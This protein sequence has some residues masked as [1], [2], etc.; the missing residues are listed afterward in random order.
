MT[1]LALPLAVCMFCAALMLSCGGDNTAT[2]KINIGLPRGVSAAPTHVGFIDRVLGFFVTPAYAQTAPEDVTAI[3]IT[4]TGPNMVP[5][6]KTFPADTTVVTLAVN[7]GKKRRIAVRGIDNTGRPKYI[8]SRVVNLEAGSMRTVRIDMGE[9]LHFVDINPDSAVGSDPSGMTLYK[10]KVYF[11]GYTEATGAELWAYD[12]DTDTASLKADIRNVEN[13][14]SSPTQLTVFNGKLYF[15]AYDGSG[16]DL[17][18]YDGESDPVQLSNFEQT[19]IQP[20]DELTV[21]GDRLFFSAHSGGSTQTT[22]YYYTEA[23][24]VVEMQYEGASLHN[25]GYEFGFT[26]FGDAVCFGA[27]DGTNVSDCELFMYNL[28]DEVI[29]KYNIYSDIAYSSH[30]HEFKVVDGSLIVAAEDSM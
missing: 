20:L 24:G 26:A 11:Q 25:E 7:A 29:T 12:L 8:G 10:N 23:D 14:S 19:G 21:V 5:F 3:G 22:A 2:L 27:Y 28:E 17:W 15:S 16:N 1:N 4:V 18:S 30:P 13:A 9:N 6:D